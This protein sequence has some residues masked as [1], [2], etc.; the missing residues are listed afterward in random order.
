MGVRYQW[1]RIVRD[2]EPLA[3]QPSAL[4]GTLLD[5]GPDM[6]E[7]CIEVIEAVHRLTIKLLKDQFAE[8]LLRPA[9][10]QMPQHLDTCFGAFPEQPGIQRIEG[11][12]VAPGQVLARQDAAELTHGCACVSKGN[13]LSSSDPLARSA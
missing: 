7:Q 3:G 10:G 2:G 1:N 4:L 8:I 13:A 5:V 9:F 12:L 11:T 6:I